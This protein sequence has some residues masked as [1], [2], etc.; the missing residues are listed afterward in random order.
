MFAQRTVQ[1]LES[2]YGKACAA[3]IIH[4]NNAGDAQ[5]TQALVLELGKM[6]AHIRSE[7]Y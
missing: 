3:L 6:Y 5:M 1:E 2:M 4:T 7:V